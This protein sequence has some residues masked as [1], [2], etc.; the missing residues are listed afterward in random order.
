MA[1]ILWA[2]FLNKSDFPTDF[3]EATSSSSVTGKLRDSRSESITVPTIPV[4][5]ITAIFIGLFFLKVSYCLK[6]FKSLN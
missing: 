2:L 3:F 1:I 6:F 5:P 4:A